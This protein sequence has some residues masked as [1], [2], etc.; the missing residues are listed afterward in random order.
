MRAILA[1]RACKPVTGRH[2]L[3]QTRPTL[4]RKFAK[5]SQAAI[6]LGKND[7]RNLL[8]LQSRRC[9]PFW[10]QKTRCSLQNRHWTPP[11]EPRAFRGR[12]SLPSKNVE[13]THKV[14]R[15]NVRDRVRGIFKGSAKESGSCTRPFVSRGFRTRSS[16]ENAVSYAQSGH[17][18][19]K[20]RS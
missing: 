2:V 6:S 18:P 3:L 1:P 14:P 7:V 8:V 9:L 10:S 4:P 15:K 12:T 17:M 20:M 5:P 11:V 13:V 19:W 16:H